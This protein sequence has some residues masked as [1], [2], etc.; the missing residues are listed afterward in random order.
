MS[1]AAITLGGLLAVIACVWT[2]QH[3][4]IIAWVRNAVGL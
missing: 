3:F 4:E 2:L 1:S